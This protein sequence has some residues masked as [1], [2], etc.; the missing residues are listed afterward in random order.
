MTGTPLF[1][2]LIATY[3]RPALLGEAIASV[4]A[5]AVDDLECIV[6]DDAGPTPATVPDDSRVRVV[7]RSANGGQ[8]ASYNTGVEHARGRYL[9]FLDDDDL[10]TPDR[11]AHALEG[12]TRAPV[13]V[14]RSRLL[15][16]TLDRPPAPGKRPRSLEGDVSATIRETMSP[17]LGQTAVDRSVML[18]FDERF[19][20]SADVEWWI[21][22]AQHARVTTVDEVGLLFRRHDGVRH[23]NDGPARMRAQLLMAEVHADYFA[24]NPRAAAHHW[25]RI[26][27]AASRAGEHATAVT[28]L[29]RSLLR[30]PDARTLWHLGRVMAAAGRSAVQR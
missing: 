3:A 10:F 23:G 28:A 9:A 14:C 6:I 7:R 18:P 20:A 29:S 27:I 8:G 17:N 21:R 24:A 19:R 25:K 22:M 26:G 13:V 2:V 16:K 30:R 5:Q 12:F 4:Q 15:A 1:S 11:L